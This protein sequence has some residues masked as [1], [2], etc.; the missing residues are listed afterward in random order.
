MVN[1]PLF[2]TRKVVTSIHGA[3][4]MIGDEMFRRVAMLAIASELRGNHP[5]ELL[6]MA[7]LRGRF[8]E[9]AANAMKQDPTEQYLLGILSLLPAML[10]VTMENVATALPLRNEVRQ[11]LL[12]L[13]NIERTILS[14]L[15]SYE[16]GEWE[17]C[18]S[19]ALPVN[20]PAPALP[21]MYAE[22]LLWADTNMTLTD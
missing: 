10:G 8:C 18:D 15:E 7:F 4:V 6:R 5:S 19:S 22:A 14:W 17:G 3:L 16:S 21:E 11:A 9:L 2:A 13:K 12:G 1:S 20:L